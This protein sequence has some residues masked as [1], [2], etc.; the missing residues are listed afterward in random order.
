MLQCSVHQRENDVGFV[1]DRLDIY[2]SKTT[3]ADPLTI[4]SSHDQITG[5]IF[6]YQ[7][8]D[9]G[10]A[11]IFECGTELPSECFGCTNRH[12]SI[13][14]PAEQV[15]ER[16]EAFIEAVEQ[17]GFCWRKPKLVWTY[18]VSAVEC[19]GRCMSQTRKKRYA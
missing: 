11:S 16:V 19:R 3:E 14:L 15:P 6:P 7:K 4:S 2:H 13:A 18:Q 9:D 17:A 5:K 8:R 1:T 10:G 12:Q